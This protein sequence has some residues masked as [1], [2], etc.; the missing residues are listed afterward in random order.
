MRP[1]PQSESSHLCGERRR[2]LKS[3][4][5]TPT[6]RCANDTSREPSPAEYAKSR[7]QRDAASFRSVDSGLRPSSSEIS[8][9]A[10]TNFPFGDDQVTSTIFV[11]LTLCMT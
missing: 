1:Q 8:L 5:R 6:V 10:P 3:H 11:V 7:H 2:C 4:G 9:P